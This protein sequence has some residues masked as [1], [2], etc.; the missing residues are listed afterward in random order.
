[1]RGEE[2]DQMK[3]LI[4]H[5]GGFSK[6][7]PSCSAKGKIFMTLP[8]SFGPLTMLDLKLI[9]LAPFGEL[10]P[11]GVFVTCADDLEPYEIIDRSSLRFG[12]DFTVFAHITDNLQ[13]ATQHGVYKV[14]QNAELFSPTKALEC[15]RVLQKPSLTFLR[16]SNSTFEHEGKESALIDSM[17]SFGHKVTKCLLA[18]ADEVEYKSSPFEVDG[19]GDFLQPLGREANADYINSQTQVRERSE[20]HLMLNKCK[21]TVNVLEKSYFVHLGTNKE[22]IAHLTTN[23]NLQTDLLLSKSCNVKF[24]GAKHMKWESCCIFNSHIDG[25]C[26]NIGEGC[27]IEFSHL[28]GE[29]DIGINNIISNCKVIADKEICM[30]LPPN[31]LWQTLPILQEEDEDGYVTLAVG[32]FDDMK[33]EVTSDADLKLIRYGEGDLLTFLTHHKLTSKA[34]FPVKSKRSIWNAQLFPVCPTPE[35]SFRQTLNALLKKSVLNVTKY[36]LY[37]INEIINHC[38][39]NAINRV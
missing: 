3:I 31:T 26:I 6:R 11:P 19:Y 4:I 20:M 16:S 5:A 38:N 14:E 37:S 22:Y 17:Y 9:T 28:S 23:T 8:T 33:Q 7:M 1:M 2:C 25:D 29:I 35:I 15:L 21:I 30:K 18:W 13:V 27:V 39:I 10:M 12:R 36:R 24:M 34:V 32:V